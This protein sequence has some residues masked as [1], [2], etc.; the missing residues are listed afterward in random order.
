[1]ISMRNIC[2]IHNES[3]E[4]YRDKEGYKIAGCVKCYAEKE[5]IDRSDIEIVND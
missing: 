2:K 3:Y 1:M 4:T 5:N